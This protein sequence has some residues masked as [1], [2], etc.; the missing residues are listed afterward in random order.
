MRFSALAVSSALLLAALPASAADMVKAKMNYD[1][2]CAACHG[3]N[4]MSMMPDAPHLRLNQGLMQ[5]D[6]QLMNKLK[7]GWQRHM[8]LIGQVSDQDILDIVTYTRNLR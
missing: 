8:P 3:F 1:R 2:L 7:M 5:H 6:M 4:G